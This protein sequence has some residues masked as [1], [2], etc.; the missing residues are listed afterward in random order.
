MLAATTDGIVCLFKEAKIK[1]F[2][3]KNDFFLNSQFV[4]WQQLLLDFIISENHGIRNSEFNQTD[5]I[6]QPWEINLKFPA[7]VGGVHTSQ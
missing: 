5:E 3:L 2:S 1:H 7:S 4:A 6:C